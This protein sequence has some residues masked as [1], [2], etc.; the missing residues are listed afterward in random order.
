[1]D[2]FI[3]RYHDIQKFHRH[4]LHHDVKISKTA[5]IYKASFRVLI[6]G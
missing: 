2:F 3:S 6:K 5:T 4:D 1:M